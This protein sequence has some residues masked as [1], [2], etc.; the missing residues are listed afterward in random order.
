MIRKIDISHK[1][2]FFIAIFLGFLWILY[3]IRDVIVLL[4]IAIIFMS[5]LSPFVEKLIKWKIPKVL[6]VA[7]VY[8]VVVSIISTLLVIV[9]VPLIDETSRL[10]KDLPA[11][12]EKAL[13]QEV[14]DRSVVQDK[15]TDIFGNAPN[16][17]INI[18]SNFVTI[19]SILVLSFYL[20]LDKERFEKLL[21]QLFINQQ[22]R[23][24]NLIEKIEYKLGAWL[25]GQIVLSLVIGTVTYILL[26]ALNIPYALPL[27]ILA[28][29]MEV[30]PVIGPIIA[31]IPAILVAYVN[32]QTPAE[33]LFVALGYLII[34]QLENH[35][36]VPQVMKRAV[37]LNPLFVILAIAIGGRLLGISGA[38]LA[39][40]IVVVMQVIVE[41]LLHIDL[42]TYSELKE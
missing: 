19:V 9:F 35:I 39:V 27:A 28:G 5:A 40:P 33:A 42:D 21:S 25:R 11:T 36:V 15:V 30:V 22:D 13:P 12:L 38:L 41:D 6:A 34:Q 4:F 10:I 14:I 1:T 2:I 26:F 17:V 23:A 18:F 3:E 8:L 16:I 32:F 20:L 24:K 29:F 31:A 37:G 7:L